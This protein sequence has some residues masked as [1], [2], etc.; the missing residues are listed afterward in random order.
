LTG[1]PWTRWPLITQLV[2]VG[3]ASVIPYFVG[4][5]LRHVGA[6]RWISVSAAVF[7]FLAVPTVFSLALLTNTDSEFLL[8]FT[9]WLIARGLARVGGRAAEMGVPAK[10]SWPI[11]TAIGAAFFLLYLVRT[12]NL[13]LAIIGLGVGFATTAKTARGIMLRA[14]GVF[15]LLTLVWIP[16]QKSWTAWSEARSAQNAPTGGSLTGILFF[17]GVFYSGTLVGHSVIK[18]ENGPCSS[19]IHESVQNNIATIGNSTRKTLNKP[20][21]ITDDIFAEHDGISVVVMW[22][23]VE[24]DFGPEEMNR[25]FWCA[26]FEGI[27]SEPR[28]LLYYYDSLVAFFLIDDLI[29]DYGYRQAWPPA[30]YSNLNA[31]IWAWALYV[32]AVIKVIALLIALGTVIPT[33][34]RG[35]SPRALAA[36]LWVAILYIAAVYVVFASPT[37]RYT[38]PAISRSR[39]AGGAW[40]RQPATDGRRKRRRCSIGIARRRPRVETNAVSA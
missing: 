5:S 24:H 22:Q 32:G 1:V 23:S 35:G 7:S 17:K 20:P 36:I 25:I 16:V 34:Q 27:R 4:S 8:Y 11:A 19:R 21:G 14:L 40:P 18:P 39:H 26:G 30:D 6:S 3:M 37:W 9:I 2:Q 38:E 28:S 15:I 12:E 33:W 10:I 31:L 13:I 29:Y